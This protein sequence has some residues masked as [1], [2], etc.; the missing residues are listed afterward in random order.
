MVWKNFAL[1]YSIR[2][3]PEHQEGLE[4][5]GTHKLL[6]CADDVNSLD[7]NTN[8]IKKNTE[9]SFDASQEVGL[10]VNTVNSICSCFITKMQDKIM[11]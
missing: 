10:E 11:I 5:N 1:E 8:T 9:N 3:V 2:K 6:V 4:L 7:E